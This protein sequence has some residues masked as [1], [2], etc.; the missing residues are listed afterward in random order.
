M[1]ENSKGRR[2]N[3]WREEGDMQILSER[4]FCGRTVSLSKFYN[5]RFET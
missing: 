2:A 4:E 5:L 3:P 1:Y